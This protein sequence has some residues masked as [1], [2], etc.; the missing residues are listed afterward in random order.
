MPSTI[1]DIRLRYTL[2]DKAGKGLDNI[3]RKATRAAASTGGLGNVLGRLGALAAGGFGIQQA[4]KALIGFNAGVEETKLQIGGML[5]LTKKTDLVDELRNADRVFTNLQ[6]RARELPGTTQEYAKFAGMITQPIM[7]AGLGMKDLEDL[8]VNSVVAAKSLGEQAEVAARD[9][10]QALRGMFRSTDPFAGKVLGSIGYKGEEGRARFNALSAQERAT[11][12]RRALMQKQWAQL[13]AAQG[14]TFNGVLSTFQDTLQQMLGKIGLPLFKAITKELKEWNAWA[15]NNG[16]KLEEWG[17]ELGETLVD[18]FRFV[19]DVV[20]FLIDNKDEIIAIGK[21]WLALRVGQGI[22]GMLGN[23]SAGAGGLAGTLRGKV[24]TNIGADIGGAFTAGM[25]GW[26]VGRRLDEA[27]GIGRILMEPVAKLAGVWSD[28]AAD[29]D[30]KFQEIQR[31]MDELDA[32][33]KARAKAAEAVGVK[34]ARA[35]QTYANLLG[36]SD[37]RANRAEKEADAIRARQKFRS[38]VY[39]PQAGELNARERLILSGAMA[40][41]GEA[42]R[43]EAKAYGAAIQTDAL[44]AG[45]LASL[46]ET[47]RRNVDMDATTQAVMQEMVRT[48]SKL[49]PNAGGGMSYQMLTYDQVL[50]IIQAVN[51]IDPNKPGGGAMKAPGKVNV[52]IQRIEVK[53]EDPDRFAF[54]LVDA[55]RDVHKNPSGAV[56][57]IR[58]G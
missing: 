17:R 54:T 3:E 30:R 13:A 28:A 21:V 2:D 25:I 19:R 12:L 50:K 11:E 27:T 15:E 53:S 43:L 8:T 45:A 46:D 29:Q 7:D 44:I 48:M 49:T 4:G 33:I 57:A 26:Q 1:Y 20:S 22:G 10:D 23:L 51:G 36:A 35:T 6:K 9:I 55:L 47:A 39:G 32:A 5:A 37:V 42:L 18:G 58:E 14:Q 41:K 40:G 38:T 24:G 34:G 52:T 16:D 31:S 56:S